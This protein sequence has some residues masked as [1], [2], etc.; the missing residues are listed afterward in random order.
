MSGAPRTALVLSGGG[1]RGAY[2]VGV[3]RELVEQ[4]F[5]TQDRRADILVG[6]S[7]GSI[8]VA[9]VAAWNDDL[10]AGIAG[11]ER[12]WREI[13]PAQVYRTDMASLGRIGA[14]WA[15]DLS[16]GGAT[17]HVQPKSLLDTAPLWELLSAH[18][19][20]ERI[21]ANVAG[22]QIAALAI[23]ATDLYTSNGVIFLDAV[24]DTPLWTRRRWRIERTPIRVEHLV[25]SSA[26]PIFFPSVAIGGRYFGDGS[27]R[28]TAP[29]SPAINLGA[30]R[31]I[32]I[33][34]SGPTP[35]TVTA[36]PLEPPTVAQVAGVLL[37]AV[38]LDAV[39]VDVEHSER[40]NASVQHH[41]TDD[42]AAVFRRVDVLWIRPSHRV[43]GLAEEL[44]HRLPGVVHYLLRG[45]GSDASVAE[46][47]SYLLF[48][49]TF[50]S[51]L[52]DLGREDVAAERERIARFFDR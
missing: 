35:E 38:M 24:P 36:S 20:F 3:L 40:V 45:L 13:H 50:C 28:N 32:A 5:L 9:A 48:D 14:Q 2:Q 47:A 22:R 41:E 17:G 51:R 34:V 30:D 26:I 8:N 29:L 1:A 21:A 42:A 39:E 10:H 12:I 52:I 43:R 11:L 44:V 27:I 19:P 33:G 25:A 4:G 15:W 7:A 37:D 23:I 18:I 46:L 49:S 31:I 6:S 16:F